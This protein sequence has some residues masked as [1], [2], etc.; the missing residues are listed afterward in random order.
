MYFFERCLLGNECFLVCYNNCN[1]FI[2]VFCYFFV[3][4]LNKSISNDNLIIRYV[5]RS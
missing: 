4:F 3:C 2:Y 1:K 5:R